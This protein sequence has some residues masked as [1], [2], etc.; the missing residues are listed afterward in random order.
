MHHFGSQTVFPSRCNRAI[1]SCV[2]KE[3]PFQQQDLETA[4]YVGVVPSVSS[5]KTRSKYGVAIPQFYVDSTKLQNSKIQYRVKDYIIPRETM[6]YG[7]KLLI[8]ND[9][10]DR[11]LAGQLFAFMYRVLYGSKMVASVVSDY[12]STSDQEAF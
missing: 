3:T 8:R 2:Y 5:E 11:R 6:V 7:Q 1:P 9:I 12:G 4:K 10:D